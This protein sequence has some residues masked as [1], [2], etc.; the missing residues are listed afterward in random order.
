MRLAEAH[1]EIESDRSQ[2]V[3]QIKNLF[4]GEFAATLRK[5]LHSLQAHRTWASYRSQASDF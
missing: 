4:K 1:T 5:F 2:A 3:T